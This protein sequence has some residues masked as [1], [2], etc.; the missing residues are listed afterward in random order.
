MRT[1]SIV[2]ALFV[3]LVLPAQAATPP[4]AQAFVSDNGHNYFGYFETPKPGQIVTGK[5]AL[6][7]IAIGPPDDFRYFA[8]GKENP[9]VPGQPV[10]PFV[11]DFIEAHPAA[12]QTAAEIVVLPD[13]FTF[14]GAKVSFAGHDPKLGNVAFE[15]TFTAAFLKAAASRNGP[16]DGPA[17][18][19][20]GDL[21]IGTA[22]FPLRLTWTG[23]G[24][25]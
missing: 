23:G 9:D 6:E 25:D 2:L 12:G 10:R 15:G 8:A 16:S 4:S 11:I 19:L 1:T 7:M 22:H 3:A 20:M 14:R 21:T 13:T 18:V 24:P 17:I 5:W